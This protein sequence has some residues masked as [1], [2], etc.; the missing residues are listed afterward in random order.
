MN[1][2]TAILTLS[3][4]TFI[5][6]YSLDP[7]KLVAEV[8]RRMQS[9]GGYDYYN[10][11]AD[12]VRAKASGATEDEI[13]YILNRSSNPSEIAH[14]R[15]AYEMFDEKFGRKRG[16][17]VFER[18]GRVRM[19]DGRLVVLVNPLF[20][21]ESS[22][23]FDVYN[24][25]AT[26]KPELDRARAGVGVHL[27]NVAFSRTAPNYN[28]KMFNA[29]DG[30]TYSTVNNTTPQAITTIAQNIVNIAMSA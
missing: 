20:S 9:S 29:V 10:I 7:S 12:A 14:N 4:N 15:A 17:G 2:T 11:L 22:R 8:S 25:W 19:C 27:M 24:I 6:Y 30:K 18:K 5:R 1:G 3:L 23:S 21:I 13:E 26:Q 16:L 28:Y